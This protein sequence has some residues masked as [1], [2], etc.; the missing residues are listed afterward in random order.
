[1]LNRF[2]LMLRRVWA[3]AAIAAFALYSMPH[4]TAQVD[5][6]GWN[7]EYCPFPSGYDADVDAGAAYVGDDAARFGNASGYDEK[8][9]YIIL[10]G[11]GQYVSDDYQL[12]WY[13]EDLGLDSRVLEIAGGRQGRF[14]FH[15]GYS[16]LPYRLFDTTSTVFTATSGDT[17]ELPPDWVTASRTSDLT[18]LGTSLRPRNIESDRTTLAA[19]AEFVAR[20]NFSFIADYRHQEREGVDIV[21]VSNFV[22]ATMLP[23]VLDFETDLVD[24]GVA[25][26]NGPLNLSLAWFG[27]FFENNADTLTWD[28]PFSTFSGADRGRL[29]QEPDNEFQQLSLSGTYKAEAIKSVIAFSAA[30]GEGEKLE[31]IL[32]YT[33]NPLLGAGSLPTSSLDGKV[34]T[35]NYAFTLTSKPFSKARL[36]LAYR[37]DERDNQSPQI[38]TSRVIVDGFLSGESELTIPYSFKR[39]KLTV[40]GDYDLFESVR[41]SAGY[42][43]KDTD[44]DFQEVAEQTEDTGWGR[45]RWR[46]TPELELDIKGGTSRRDIDSY[47]EVF[48]ATLDQNPLLRKYNLAYRYREFGEVSLSFSPAE[49][50]VSVSLNALFADDS[51]TRSELGMLSADEF[52]IAADLSWSV[53][54]NTSVY[55]NAG[56]EDIESL[57]AGSVL[58]AAPDWRAT[59]DDDFT[60]VGA[61]FRMRGISE[62]FD[63]QFD[64]VR[65]DGESEIVVQSFGRTPSEFPEL[66]SELDNL[67]VRLS[68]RRSERLTVNLDLRYERFATED[69]ALQGV[70]PDTIPAVLSLGAQPYDYDVFVLGLGFGYRIGGDD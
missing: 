62:N 12:G 29:A 33:I 13:A 11:S 58:F 10:G 42:D 67:R 54:D 68:Y 24:L 31:Q 16:E 21:S 6:S 63:L 53:S 28:N 66:Q 27:S 51:F 52:H 69:W 55:L 44:R 18:A 57:Q 23:R 41:I 37:V 5:T 9:A 36:K 30:V 15:L 34:D 47:N 39:S 26:A 48:A 46:P 8:G 32:P 40:R 38:L 49:L 50:P 70:A 35:T 61:G 17:L 45:L 19:G 60:T 2:K 20:S 65:S 3:C 4:A 22:Q 64:Y 1:M 25:Y 43:R 59:N 56:I 7:C 14:G